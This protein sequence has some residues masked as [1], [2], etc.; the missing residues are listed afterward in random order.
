MDGKLYISGFETADKAIAFAI[1]YWDENLDAIQAI[2]D[3]DVELGELGLNKE[4][5]CIVGVCDICKVEGIY[6]M[7]ACVYEDGIVG[8]ECS[9]CENLSLYPKEA[10]DGQEES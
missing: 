9:A 3:E 10:E 5:L 4:W 1:Q 2:R 7:P 6:F 8:V